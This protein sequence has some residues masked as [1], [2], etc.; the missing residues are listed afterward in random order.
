MVVMLADY[1]V[2]QWVG[3]MVVMSADLL[4]DYLVVQRVGRMVV[5]S[6]DL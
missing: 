3:R 5:M 1:W 2:V 4:A 6:A